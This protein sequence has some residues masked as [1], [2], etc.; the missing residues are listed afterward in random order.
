MPLSLKY[1]IGAHMRS[2]ALLRD[3]PLAVS[4]MPGMAM[5]AVG[6]R[7]SPQKYATRIICPHGNA[8]QSTGLM[9]HDDTFRDHRD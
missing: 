5:M 8:F 2:R 1:Y 9:A 3:Q 4:Q 7:L 6:M